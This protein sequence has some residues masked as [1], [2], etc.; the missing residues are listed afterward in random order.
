[1]NRPL[2]MIALL[3]L[4]L[5]IA[6]SQSAVF[7]EVPLLTPKEL[8][9]DSTHIVIGKVRGIYTAT[10]IS[11]DWRHSDS[12]VEILVSSIEKGDG[13]GTV[14]YA[15]LW[16]KEWIGDGEPAPHS[17]GHHGVNDG[18]T[19]RAHL[20]REGG[21]YHVLLPNGLIP[22]KPDEA[23]ATKTASDDADAELAAIQGKWS[24]SVETDRGTYKIVKEH[25]G[26]TTTLTVT[27][28][29]DRVIEAK[30]SE[31]RL[32]TTSKIRV[33]T[34]FNNT[35]TAG[36]NKGHTIDR[37]HSYVYGIENDKFYEVRGLLIDEDDALSVIV[38]DRVQ[39]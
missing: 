37:P 31:F 19:I 15:H 35:F 22:V 30:S 36:P 38:W 23:E 21:T 11:E 6:F 24:R 32:D 12:I 5:P 34:F 9:S 17:R 14:V 39:D 4:S 3:A 10:K 1:M 33:F 28:S 27:D 7:A 8:Q 20:K 16:N 25:K 29:N 26:N 18:E 13:I 2:R